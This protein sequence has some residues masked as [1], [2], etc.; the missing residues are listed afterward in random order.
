[1]GIIVWSLRNVEVM[2]KVQKDREQRA[3][4]IGRE[5]VSTSWD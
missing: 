2:L 3:E 1:M 4:S 5:Q